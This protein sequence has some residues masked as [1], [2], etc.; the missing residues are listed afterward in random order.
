MDVITERMERIDQHLAKFERSDRFRSE[1]SE[2]PEKPSEKFPEKSQAPIEPPMELFT[3]FPA[4]PATKPAP[5][6]SEPTPPRSPP[7]VSELLRIARLC[8]LKR[9]NT[10]RF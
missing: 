10:G 7:L 6:F 1:Q 3:L 4:E 2:L 5:Q 9:F 8:F